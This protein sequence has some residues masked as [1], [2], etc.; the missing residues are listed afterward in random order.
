MKFMRWLVF[1]W[2]HRME[3]KTTIFD[4]E[5]DNIQFHLMLVKI[6]NEFWWDFV[7]N[8]Q[9]ICI[10]AHKLTCCVTKSPRQCFEFYQ[11]WKNEKI[12]QHLTRHLFSYLFIKLNTFWSLSTFQWTLPMRTLVYYILRLLIKIKLYHGIKLFIQKHFYIVL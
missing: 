4:T 1:W 12:R 5:I 9:A 8:K 11:N 6:F 3:T 7:L 10:S 2:H